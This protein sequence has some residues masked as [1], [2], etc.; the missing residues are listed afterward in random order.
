MYLR[1]PAIIMK[2]ISL[3]YLVWVTLLILGLLSSSIHA[4]E[5]I[6]VAAIFAKTGEAATPNLMYFYSARFAV[7]EINKKGGLLGKP[8]ALIEID[9]QSTALGSKT[10][11]EQ[12]VKDGVTAVIGGS[13]SS[14]ALAM[15]PVLQA[16][17][18]PMISPSATIL[19]LTRVGDYIFRA[20]FVDEFQ[21]AVMAT[22]AIRDL[23]AKTAVVLTNTGNK[24]SMDLAKVF[25]QQFKK[26][27]GKIL[28]E[29]EY[30]EDVTDFRALVEQV[31]QLKPKVVFIPGYSKDTGY[32]MKTAAEM[33]IKLH[34]LGGD[35]WS[36]E[37]I[38][39]YAGDA[40]NGNYCCSNWNKDNPDKLSLRFVEVFEKSYGRI[41]AVSPALTYDAFM[42]LA[43]AIRRANSLDQAKIRKALASTRGFRGV[44][45][46]IT[47]DTHRNPVNKPAV[48]LKYEKGATV[49]V[50]TIKP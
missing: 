35:G 50:K 36:E 27:G 48:I 47:Y 5:T 3:I 40:V 49:Y 20:C 6:K 33:G 13:R 19:E 15:A 38:Y 14:H 41:V 45:G 34:Y 9:N 2:R 12:A 10:A 42:L 18:T 26:T 7:E 44:T 8:I 23:K 4:S 24:Y 21:G 28:L 39:Q 22:F 1:R 37:M 16:A 43:D 46:E 17:K 25:A 30:L 32:I 11:A 29:G 31:S